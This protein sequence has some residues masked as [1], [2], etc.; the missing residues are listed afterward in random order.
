[1]LGAE[2]KTMKMGTIGV[3]SV[4]SAIAVAAASRARVR[5]FVLVDRPRQGRGHRHALRRR[6]LE[7]D[8]SQVPQALMLNSFAAV[9]PS[10]AT[11]CSSLSELQAKMWSTGFSCQG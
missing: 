11:F 10:T 6:S 3:G 7:G 4:G 1:M 5:E 8:R 9:P 2:G